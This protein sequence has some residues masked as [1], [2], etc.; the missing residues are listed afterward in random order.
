M[1]ENDLSA[2]VGR[3]PLGLGAGPERGGGGLAAA[4]AAGFASIEVGTV[5]AQPEPDHN[6]GAVA[7][8]QRLST[9]DRQACRIGVN[10]GSQFASVPSQI[11]ADWLDAM[12]PLA[13]LANF[14]T[15][16]LS[17]PYYTSL[18]STES[19]S[20]VLDAIA[21]VADEITKPL[22]VKLP[23]GRPAVAANVAWL[24]PLLGRSGIDSIV[25]SSNS[26]SAN[27]PAAHIA[28]AIAASGLPVIAT[29]GVRTARDLQDRLSAG[30][31]GVQIYSLFAEN[32]SAA[33]AALIDVA[34]NL[35]PRPT[36]PP[37]QLLPLSV[38]LIQA[39]GKSRRR[40]DGVD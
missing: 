18:L 34:E 3:H 9:V 35:A 36:A 27:P 4:L 14:F 32:G 30:A 28:T 21:V 26:D 15:L 8:A 23:F 37:G 6:P 11:G 12:A 10:I 17:A 29:G 33:V 16:N 40:R 2:V 13:K 7:L 20:K 22:L 38:G 5:T 24:L 1:A 19:R 25:V 31:V 39:K